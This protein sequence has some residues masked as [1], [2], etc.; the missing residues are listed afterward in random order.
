[1]TLAITGASG[2]TGWRIADEALKR[3][4][5]VRAILRAGSVLPVALQGRDHL[6]W[7]GLSWVMQAA[8]GRRCRDAMPC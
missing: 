1:M 8:C 7:C 6:E 5:A 3:G 2:K 4:Q